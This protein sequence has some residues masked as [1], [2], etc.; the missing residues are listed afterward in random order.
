MIIQEIR[1]GGGEKLYEFT[2]SYL[3]QCRFYSIFGEIFARKKTREFHN[4]LD[5][6]AKMFLIRP[7]ED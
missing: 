7:E 5:F 4:Y 6:R 2:A 1:G 3:M